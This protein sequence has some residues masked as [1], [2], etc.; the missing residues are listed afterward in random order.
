MRGPVKPALVSLIIVVVLIGILV[1]D[2][3]T[4]ETPASELLLYCAAGMKQP[5]A[6]IAAE[7]ER[8]YG[9]RV[10]LQYGGSGTLLSSLNVAQ[11]GD[12]YLAADETYIELAREQALV[13]EAIPVA[14]IRP[15]IVVPRGNPNG[16]TGIDDLNQNELRVALGLPEAASVGRVTQVLLE[17]TGQWATLETRVRANGVFKPTVNE[18]A[19]DVAIGA[20]DAGIVWDATVNQ[21]EELESVPIA[22]SDQVV[23]NITVG[24]LRSTNQ[25][26]AALRFAR[27]MAAREKGLPVFERHG[28]PPL[29]GDVWAE[30]PEITYF[31]GGVNR[32]A[33]EQ[34]LAEF[35]LREGVS[36]N[37]SYNGCGILVGQMK[38]GARP[39]VYHSCDLSFME[40]VTDLFHE[41]T[42]VTQTDMVIMTQQG[43]PKGIRTLA[44]LAA[45]GIRLGTA[46]ED[47]SA[48][49]ALTA[50][51]LQAEGLYDGVTKNVV[52]QMPTADLLVNQIQAGS[53]DAVI[54]YQAN[55]VVA[56][57]DAEVIPITLPTAEAFQTFAIGKDSEHKQL[58]TRLYATLQSAESQDRFMQTGFSWRLGSIAP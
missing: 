30:R 50:R 29:E 45:E 1:W 37:T 28:F 9:V 20:V 57:K 51:L 43:N 18:V 16:I 47:Q 54:V 2:P 27:Y 6:E 7:Y 40:E 33:I 15:V 31:S 48:L 5:V 53:L 11:R 17:A 42:V 36:I 49:G 38:T 26:A 4:D 44:D 39:D 14:Q 32:T 23:Q 12:L 19:A 58:L 34:T 35:A 56:R 3:R 22:A 24:I 25:P 8:E 10:T 21:F 52:T 13:D 46:N 55:T 41:A